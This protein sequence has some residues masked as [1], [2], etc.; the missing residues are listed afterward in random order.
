MPKPTDIKDLTP[1]P[2]N[3]RTHTPRNLGMLVDALQTV[4]AARSIVIDEGG[5][6]L[7]GNGVLEAAAEAGITRLQVVD[8]DGQTLVAVR[9]RGLSEEQ[10]RQLAIYDNRVAEL[11]EWNIEQLRL[12][13]VAGLDLKP[14]WTEHELSIL[15]KIDTPPTGFPVIDETLET[16]HTCPK[17]GYEWSGKG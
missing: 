15:A 3:R 12:D 4:G 16:E 8:T 14:F 7:A 9:R 2:H 10:K 5:Q 13:A 1:D 11:A 6:V 17:C